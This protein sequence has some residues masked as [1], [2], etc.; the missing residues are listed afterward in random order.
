MILAIDYHLTTQI[1]FIS[2][3]SNVAIRWKENLCS[4]FSQKSFR[5]RVLTG[6][7]EIAFNG[8]QKRIVYVTFSCRRT[9]KNSGNFP[10]LFMISLICHLTRRCFVK[11][12]REMGVCYPLRGCLITGVLIIKKIIEKA[13]RQRLREKCSYLVLSMFVSVPRSV[14]HRKPS[15]PRFSL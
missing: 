5:D 9:C 11:P 14:R 1:S 2:F 10:V 4:F 3:F 8:L 13:K 12:Y 15:S 7:Q 6:G